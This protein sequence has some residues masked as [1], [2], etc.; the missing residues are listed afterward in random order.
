MSVTAI[1]TPCAPLPLGP[2][3]QAVRADNLLWVSGQLPVHPETQELV[4]GG[5]ERSTRQCLENLKAILDASGFPMSAVVKTTLYLAD[6][7]DFPVVDRVYGEYFAE[8]H[9]A[10]VTVQVAALP[11]GARLEMDAVAVLTAPPTELPEV[12]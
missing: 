12:P 8:P 11:K 4:E 6:L 7:A 2:Y 5:I 10:R 9:P 3:S 1:L